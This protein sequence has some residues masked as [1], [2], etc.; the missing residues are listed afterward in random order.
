MS[1]LEKR[2]T[3]LIECDI[4]LGLPRGRNDIT[5]S[6]L[7]GEKWEDFIH[8][9]PG[10]SIADLLELAEIS[11]KEEYGE[12]PPAI[13]LPTKDEH[14]RKLEIARAVHAIQNYSDSTHWKDTDVNGAYYNRK[15]RRKVKPQTL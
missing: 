3:V 8:P 5:V 7:A 11:Y 2:S 1:D 9:H 6:L 13:K 15:N 4:T 12:A 14:E 10:V